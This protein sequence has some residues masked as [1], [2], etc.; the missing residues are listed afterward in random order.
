MTL[1]SQVCSLE[2]ATKLKEL[3]V[4][5]E[6]LFYHHASL[7]KI[8]W[9]GDIPISRSEFGDRYIPA[10]T[11]AEL[12][13]MLPT[14]YCLSGKTEYEEPFRAFWCGLENI[15][16]LWAETEAEARAQMLIHL[17]E[18]HLVTAEDINKGAL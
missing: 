2:S 10:F 11:V 7:N 14:D 8:S 12:G 16:W 3:G 4:Q 18:N 5:R 17:L 13:E 1:E 9:R 15:S 6:S